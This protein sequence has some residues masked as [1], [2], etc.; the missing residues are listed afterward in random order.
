MIRKATLTTLAA[1]ATILAS[2]AH[3]ETVPSRDPVISTQAVPSAALLAG[4]LGTSIGVFTVVAVVA[5]GIVVAASRGGSSSSSTASTF[6]I[7][8]S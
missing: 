8:N 5:G 4:G 6:F 3:A 7:P 2:V 1:T